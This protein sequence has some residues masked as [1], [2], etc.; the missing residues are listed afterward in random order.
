MAIENKVTTLRSASVLSD[1]EIQSHID[2]Q[3][4]EGWYLV[5]LD[6]MVGWYRF[7][8]AKITE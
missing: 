8:W 7:F 2:S 4:E 3:N 5:A 6:N 1:E